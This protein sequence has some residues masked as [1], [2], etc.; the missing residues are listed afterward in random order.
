MKITK[1]LKIIDWKSKYYILLYIIF[2]KDKN[3]VQYLSKDAS[4]GTSK[5]Q[6]HFKIDKTLSEI[7]IIP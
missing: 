4:F 2:S 5:P 1:D 6:N 3:K 7:S